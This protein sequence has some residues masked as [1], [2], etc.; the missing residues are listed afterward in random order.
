MEFH[1]V[2]LRESYVDVVRDLPVILMVREGCA[3]YFQFGKSDLE[4]I[5]SVSSLLITTRHHYLAQSSRNGRTIGILVRAAS[6][7]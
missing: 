3:R 1:A 6:S 4:M 5:G 7:R 2:K